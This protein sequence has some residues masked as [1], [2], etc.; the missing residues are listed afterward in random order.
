MEVRDS[1]YCFEIA[2]RSVGRAALHL[3]IENMS[4]TALDVMADVLLNY[5][6]R[7]GRS[8]SHLAET[9]GRTSAHVNLLDALRACEMEAAPA[10][11]QMH[12]RDPNT[13]DSLYH[14]PNVAS[15]SQSLMINANSRDWKG[16]ACFLFGPKWLEDDEKQ[17]VEQVAQASAGG[18]KQFPKAA[19]SNK[20][21]GW[22]APYPDEIPHFP[23]ASETCANPHPLAAKQIL[24]LHS[25]AEDDGNLQTVED[26]EAALQGIPDNAFLESSWGSMT[27]KKRKLED[28]DVVMAEAADTEQSPATKKTK[29]NDGTADA[30]AAAK[31]DESA[32]KEN[33]DEDKPKE[34]ESKEAV[35]EKP[36]SHPHV[37]SFYPQPPSFIG[38]GQ[39]GSIKVLDVDPTAEGPASEDKAEYSHQ[40]RSS[41]VQL[42]SYWGSGWDGEP[43][44]KLAV[45]VGRV[46]AQPMSSSIVPLG[47]AS[48]SRVSRILEGSLDAAAMQ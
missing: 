3:G 9:N 21:Q 29:L 33:S 32:E 4:E 24:S 34:E 45:P 1:I 35:E 23:Q 12:L 22:Q 6:H 37:P 26:E 11:Q 18:G 38:N 27:A 28:E 41:L 25:A 42:G 7:V 19:E 15:N 40:V 48:G 13:D 44:T 5:L 16:L 36:D 10:V 8:L 17:P 14:K 43:N 20:A 31:P 46:E 39:E 47:R 30:A 2:R